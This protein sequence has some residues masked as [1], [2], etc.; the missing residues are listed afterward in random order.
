MKIILLFVLLISVYQWF[1]IDQINRTQEMILINQRNLYDYQQEMDEKVRKLESERV[2]NISKPVGPVPTIGKGKAPEAPVK[3]GLKIIKTKNKLNH[4]QI[5]IFCMA[6]NIYH[7]AGNQSKLGKY[8][9]AQ[10]TINRKFSSEYPNTICDVVM[11]DFQFSWA[12]DRK[13]RW[14]RPKGTVWNESLKIAEEVI[15]GGKR[16]EGLG[17]ALFYHADYVSPNWK[18]PDA[19]LAKVGAHIFYADAR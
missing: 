1:S 14:T 15:R 13:I 10:V 16:V 7:E 12:N 18:K 2:L 11:Q 9:V 6:K 3:D 4:K 5:D 17:T 8:A 19:K